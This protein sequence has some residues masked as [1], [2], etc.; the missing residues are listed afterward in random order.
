L[1]YLSKGKIPVVGTMAH[2]YILSFTDASDLGSL[3]KMKGIDIVDRAMH[4]RTEL[5]WTN[6]NLS[7]L[8]SFLSYASCNEEGFL[9]LVDTYDTMGSGVKNFLLAALVLDEI[10]VKA[11]GIRL[12]SGD[13]A[14]LSK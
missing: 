8:F 2:S 5:G 4:Y 12:D 13:L 14:E 3:R 10:G 6:T 11:K 7:E 1:G 9:G